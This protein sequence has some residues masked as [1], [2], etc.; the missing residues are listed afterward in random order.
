MND[1]IGFSLRIFVPNDDPK[2]LRVIEKSQWSGKG[3]LFPRTIFDSIKQLEEL[4]NTGVYIL[5]ENVPEGLLPR[6]YIGESDK[7]KVRL[8]LHDK[9][10]EF[11]DNCVA[12]VS[13]DK[14]L[15]KAHIRYLEARLV[16]L[17]KEAKR[18]ELDSGTVPQIPTLAPADR[19]D[20]ELYLREMLLCLPVIGVRFFEKPSGQNQSNT[21]FDLNSK[22]VTAKG[23]EESGGFTVLTGS[24]AVKSETNSIHNHIKKLRLALQ[25]KGI[26]KDMGTTFEFVEDYTFGSLSAAASVVLGM[27]ANG[28][29]YWKKQ[30]SK[31]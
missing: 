4:D 2:G 15:N 27:S 14:Y 3:I 21:V 12:F 20:A 22:G 28:R 13:K 18:C 30:S 17:A 25:K 10:K 23:Y 7:L 9:Q 16:M 19:S 31:T 29:Y 8:D 6:V 26:L 24:T 11:W 5:W 1:P